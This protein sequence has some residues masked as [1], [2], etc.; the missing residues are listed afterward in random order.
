MNNAPDQSQQE[1]REFLL[2]MTRE[3]RMLVVVNSELYGG[4]W[5]EM[6][7]DLNARLSG[8]TYIFK[9]ASRIEDDLARI[10]RIT[11]FE[12]REGVHLSDYIE[13]APQDEA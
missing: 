4:N 8:G 9:L 2:R 13:F 10:E 11:D 1:L 7:A 12:G 5:D 3:E 6:V